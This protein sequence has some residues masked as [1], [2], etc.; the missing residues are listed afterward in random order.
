MQN[1]VPCTS[2]CLMQP[3]WI[4]CN[5]LFSPLPRSLDLSSFS[6]KPWNTCNAIVELNKHCITFWD[7][8]F[9]KNGPVHKLIVEYIALKKDRL[10]IYCLLERRWEGCRSFQLFSFSFFLFFFSLSSVFRMCAICQIPTSVKM[11]FFK[12]IHHFQTGFLQEIPE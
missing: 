8:T 7:I 11:Q 3:S 4:C 10:C 1:L 9:R 5:M 6:F 12:K 2:C